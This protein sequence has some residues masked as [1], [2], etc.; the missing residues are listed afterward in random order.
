MNG[1]IGKL[2]IKFKDFKITGTTEQKEFPFEY[3]FKKQKWSIFGLTVNS[4]NFLKISLFVSRK[5]CVKTAKT[6][7][8]FWNAISM[9]TEVAIFK[10]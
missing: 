3:M 2:Q 7:E 5:P 4:G 6:S 10:N 8:Q 1:L 9:V